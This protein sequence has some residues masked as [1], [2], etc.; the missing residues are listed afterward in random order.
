MAVSQNM[1]KFH[2]TVINQETGLPKEDVDLVAKGN[3]IGSSSSDGSFTIYLRPGTKVKFIAIGMESFERTFTLED[4][5]NIIVNVKQEVG[6][7]K[8]VVVQGF[9]T[10][11]RETMTGA[12]TIISGKEIQDVPVSNVTQLLQ[13]KVAGLNV[14]INN[15]AP[16]ART[17]MFLRGISSASVSGAGSSAFMTPTSPLFVVDG[18]QVDD[19]ANYSYGFDQAGPGI[20]PLSTIPPEDVESIEVLKDAAATAQ[21]GS[22]GAYGVILITT[23]RGKSAVPIVQYTGSY[24]VNLIPKLRDVI[25]GRD[26]RDLRINQIIQYDSTYAA[27]LALIN[28]NYFLSDS[29]SPYF[30]NSTNW[31]GIAYRTSSNMN[32]N[33]NVSGGDATFNYKANINYYKEASILINTGLSRYQLN[34]NAQYKPNQRFN[35]LATVSTSMVE[36]Q[37]GSGVGLVQ[38]SLSTANKSSSLLPSPSNYSAN[39]AAVSSFAVRD[40][41]KTATLNSSLNIQWEPIKHIMLGTNGSY[42]V[43]SATS[44]NYTPAYVNSGVGR[45]ISYNYRLNTLYDRSTASW[46]NTY[47]DLHNFSVFAFSEINKSVYRSNQIRLNGTAN[48][49]IESPLGNDSY[50]SYGGVVTYGDTRSLAYGGSFSYNYNQKYVVDF[51]FRTDGTST[52]GPNSGW[53]QNPVGSA[54]WNFNKENYFQHHALWLDYGSLRFSY[55]STTIP[56][57][58]IYD[59]Y[60]KYT[61]GPGYNGNSSIQN[62]WTNIPNPNFKTT[63]NTSMDIGFEASV[64]KNFLNIVYDY[65][66][67]RID[68][69]LIEKSIANINAYSSVISN[70]LA[71]VDYGHEL[72]LSFRPIAP[73]DGNKWQW[74]FSINGSYNKDVLTQLPDGARQLIR[75]LTDDENTKYPVLQRLGR[76]VFTNLLYNTRGVYSTDADVPVDPVTGLRQHV[77]VNGQNYYFKGGDPIFTDLNGDYVI[78]S[79]D[80][81]AVG[82][83]YPKITGGFTSFLQ[84]SKWSLN[85][86]CSYTLKR[87]IINTTAAERFSY[88]SDPTN[89]NVLVPIDQY[90]YWRKPGD[91]AKYPNPFDF[92]NSPYIDPYRINQTLYLEDGSYFKINSITLAYNFDRN[93]TKRFGIT[94]CRAYVTAGNVYT[95]SKYSGPDPENVTDLGYDNSNGYPNRRTL[96]FGV[97]LQ[98]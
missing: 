12:S 89:L 56:T 84:Y 9:Q 1:V 78:D 39:N 98:F 87:D 50:T 14:Q 82:S 26:E 62:T 73:K 81:V 13:G 80:R 77:V 67:K 38:T 15:G 43:N 69:Q 40:N 19:N 71:N 3:K 4:T 90:N 44:D 63:V 97:N 36:N 72:T 29:L 41:N 59:V 22:R 86:V 30:N 35:M 42:S 52:N 47:N 70:E 27:A 20:S 8:E 33:V 96:T 11:T 34:M 2:G 49:N 46:I 48:D 64:F 18:V 23:K 68:N 54:R 60:G 58:T 55:G 10:K 88:Y 75:G 91:V 7:M 57:G 32:H 61:A 45:T 92:I 5:G 51:S 21:Y 66:Y 17:S 76:T 95:F 24:F 28:T 37:K 85:I 6:A 65:Y 93:Y 83:P 16:G 74:N 79:L 94:S 53:K 25:G 31:Q